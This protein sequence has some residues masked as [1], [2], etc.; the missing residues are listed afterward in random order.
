MVIIFLIMMTHLI[1][2]I[3]AIIGPHIRHKQREVSPKRGRHRHWQWWCHLQV[4]HHDWSFHCDH[5]HH[6]LTI[7]Q[8][9]DFWF[10]CDYFDCNDHKLW[11]IMKNLTNAISVTMHA[12]GQ[13]IWRHTWQNMSM[14]G[15]LT[16]F[17]PGLWAS[18]FFHQAFWPPSWWRGG[19]LW[20]GG[21]YLWDKCRRLQRLGKAYIRRF[22]MNTC[23]TSAT[24]ASSTLAS[25]TFSII[26]ISI[27][28]I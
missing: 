8:Y 17:W 9:H 23:G 14:V 12:L 16:R 19:L 27:T 18:S 7:W 25:P 5:H 20:K 4:H 6:R 21:D 13:T 10:H 1:K 11:K 26:D 28:N 24:L 22:V 3:I 15:S 2:M